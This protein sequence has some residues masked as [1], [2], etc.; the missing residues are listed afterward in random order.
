VPSA[1]QITLTSATG[2]APFTGSF[3]LTASGG[4]VTFTITVPQGL[5]VS[6]TSGSLA[7]GESIPITVT[8]QNN[9]PPSSFPLTL[10]PGPVT[11]TVLL[12]LP[13]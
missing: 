10:S 5:T 1:P 2:G 9:P 4:P 7:A 13:T 3:T 8:D 12:P 6:P 11:V